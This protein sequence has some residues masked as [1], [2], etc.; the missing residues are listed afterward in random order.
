MQAGIYIHIP[1]CR[2]RCSYCDFATDVFKNEE[3]VER[4]VNALIKEVQS[5]KF[6]VQIQNPKSKI[7]VD[8]IYFGGGTPSL[9]KPKQLEKILVASTARVSERRLLTTR[10]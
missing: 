7:P 10:N 9:L 8:T 2:S 3:T 4:Y 1:F 5:S 6:K